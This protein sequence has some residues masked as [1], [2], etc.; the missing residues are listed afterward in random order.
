MYSVNLL[1]TQKNVSFWTLMENETIFF[2][3]TERGES[4]KRCLQALFVFP[5]SR[6]VTK[7]SE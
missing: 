7:S 5:Q 1:Q 4:W 2:V 3:F 6:E